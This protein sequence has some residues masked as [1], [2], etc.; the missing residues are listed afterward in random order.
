VEEG[1]GRHTGISL[2]M[3]GAVSGAQLG[4]AQ[5]ISVRRQGRIAISIYSQYPVLA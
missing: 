3:L 4:N 5:I 2:F 1:S